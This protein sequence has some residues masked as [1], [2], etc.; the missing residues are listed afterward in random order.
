M[1]KTKRFGTAVVCG[2][3]L[4]GGFVSEGELPQQHSDGRGRVHAVEER[5]QFRGHFPH[6]NTPNPAQSIHGFRLSLSTGSGYQ[7]SD[8]VPRVFEPLSPRVDIG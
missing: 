3:G 5:L 6:I 4:A 8:C 2:A 7:V 1:E